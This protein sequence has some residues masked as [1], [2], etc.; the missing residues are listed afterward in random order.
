MVNY[1]T[2]ITIDNFNKNL[3][4]SGEIFTS[5]LVFKTSLVSVEE[6]EFISPALNKILKYSKWNFDLED[7]DHIFRIENCP[8]YP[9]QIILLFGEYG[10][11]CEELE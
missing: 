3:I 9:F 1:K 2:D 7:C 10:F 4:Q 8:L 11:S 6:A 5:V